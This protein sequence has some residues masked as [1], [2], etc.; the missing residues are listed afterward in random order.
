MSSPRVLVEGIAQ[1]AA[2]RLVMKCLAAVRGTAP[3]APGTSL[4][5]GAQ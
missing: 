1:S 5:A 2:A 3:S 4:P